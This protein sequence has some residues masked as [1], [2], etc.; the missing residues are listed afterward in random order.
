MW[1]ILITKNDGLLNK[2]C[3][4]IMHIFSRTKKDVSA[5]YNRIWACSAAGYLKRHESIIGNVYVVCILLVVESVKY[6]LLIQS[7]ADSSMH[8]SFISIMLKHKKIFVRSDTFQY[9]H[10]GLHPGLLLFALPLAPAL[11]NSPYWFFILYYCFV[12]GSDSDPFLRIGSEG[13]FAQS[14]SAFVSLVSS[15]DLLV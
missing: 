15:N 12:L 6:I 13:W 3:L 1:I 9:G 5:V 2:M 10:S 11:L 14:C 7:L 4:S 8:A